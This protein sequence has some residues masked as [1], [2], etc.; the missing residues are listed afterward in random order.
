MRRICLDA[1]LSLSVHASLVV[2]TVG[3]RQRNSGLKVSAGGV[4][5]LVD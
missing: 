5:E 3:E 1:K 2:D 4:R